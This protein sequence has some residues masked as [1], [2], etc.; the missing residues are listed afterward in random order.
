MRYFLTYNNLGY[1]KVIHSANSSLDDYKSSAELAEDQ[2]CIEHDF[3]GSVQHFDVYVDVT[4]QPHEVKI[5]SVLN[6]TPSK[7]TILAGGI[8][9]T[10]ISNIPEGVFVTWP[11]GQRDEVTDGV[12]EFSATQ[13]DTYVLK[14]DGV[15]YLTEEVSIEAHV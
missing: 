5:K 3:S 7:T 2:A 14:F 8:E 6:L 13:P 9:E 11:D 15:K 12:V 10:V 1:V 4:T